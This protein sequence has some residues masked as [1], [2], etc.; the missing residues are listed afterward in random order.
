MLRITGLPIALVD[1]QQVVWEGEPG[2]SRVL[3]VIWTNKPYYNDYVGKNYTLPDNANVW[4]TAVPELK[5]FFKD[6]SANITTLRAEQLLGVPPHYGCTKFVELWVEP[7][8][9]F[10]PSPD[11]EIIDC[12]ADLDFPTTSNRFLTFDD[13]MLI[14]E[15][16]YAEGVDKQYTYM[17]WFNHRKEIIYS[18]DHPYPWTRLGYTYDWENPD[19]DVGLSE[20]VIIDG[21]TVGV[22]SI[23][24]NDDY[25]SYHPKITHFIAKNTSMGLFTP[26]A[27]P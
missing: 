26:Q 3:V 16:D 5:D 8:D 25:F 18:G 21:S 12:E 17:E 22:H 6:S 1:D 27:T 13:N 23:T 24:A 19:S 14:V 15:H 9:L 10:R 4:V 11:P 7:S 20:F 2:N